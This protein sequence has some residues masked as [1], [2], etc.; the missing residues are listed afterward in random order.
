MLGLVHH[1]YRADTFHRSSKAGS[2]QGTFLGCKSVLPIHEGSNREGIA[3][4]FSGNLPHREY[5]E[6]NLKGYAHSTH[7]RATYD[8]I[9]LSL[10]QAQENTNYR[11]R[12]IPTVEGLPPHSA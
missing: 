8:E 5:V 9:E 12:T 2:D 7:R 10:N 11:G 3:P 4:E 6:P 1:K